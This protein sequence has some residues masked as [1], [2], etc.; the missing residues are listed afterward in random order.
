MDQ[1]KVE[2]VVEWPRLEFRKDLQRLM[3][4]ANF[5]RC[6]I[7]Y[8]RSVTAPLMALIISLDIHLEP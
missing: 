5:Y 4:F 8:Y 6:F 1:K 2:A 3:G 7:C